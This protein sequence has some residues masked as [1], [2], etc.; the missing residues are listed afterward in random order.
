MEKTSKHSSVKVK[1]SKSND[2]SRH[3]LQER[4]NTSEGLGM[5]TDCKVDSPEI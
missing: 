1:V 4:K 5:K 2:V 3:E